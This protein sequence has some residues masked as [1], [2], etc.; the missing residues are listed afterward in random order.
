MTGT[1]VT[2]RHLVELGLKVREAC[3]SKGEARE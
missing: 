2:I 3:V 1:K